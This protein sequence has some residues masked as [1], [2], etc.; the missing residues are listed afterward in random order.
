MSSLERLL[1]HLAVPALHGALEL[2]PG[3]LA[4]RLEEKVGLGEKERKSER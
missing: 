2:E 1:E 4:L 3:L